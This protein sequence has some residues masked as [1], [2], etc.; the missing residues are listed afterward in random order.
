MAHD[1]ATPYTQQVLE[2]RR[3][4]GELQAPR[5]DNVNC[6]L[7]GLPSRI[8]EREDFLADESLC[9]TDTDAGDRLRMSS[10]TDAKSHLP[11]RAKVMD[12][13]LGHYRPAKR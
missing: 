10:K 5:L 3:S 8:V 4:L 9:I 13:T 7:Y 1:I 6:R 12:L 11:E 2:K